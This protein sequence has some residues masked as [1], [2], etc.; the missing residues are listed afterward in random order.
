MEQS[1]CH[2]FLIKF[3][4]WRFF[5][6]SRVPSGRN[7]KWLLSSC[8]R[9]EFFHEIKSQQKTKRKCRIYKTDIRWSLGT[10]SNTSCGNVVNRLLLRANHSNWGMP[11]KASESISRRLFE[12]I[13]N[14]SS[15]SMPVNTPD[16]RFSSKLPPM[17]SSCN[18]PKLLKVKKNKQIK[19]CVQ[20]FLYIFV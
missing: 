18:C 14:F 1:Q 19:C 20:Y 5:K 9:W 10:G 15:R 17:C 16:G 6:G 7:M 4:Y 8:L 2:G 13:N 3:T 12:S 11:M